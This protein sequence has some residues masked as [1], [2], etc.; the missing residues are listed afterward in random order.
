MRLEW[1][2]LLKP[3][4]IWMNEMLKIIEKYVTP[5]ESSNGIVFLSICMCMCLYI[6]YSVPPSYKVHYLKLGGN[7][8]TKLG[9]KVHL[10]VA[11]TSLMSYAPGVAG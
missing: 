2:I 7:T 3:H 8:V 6:N 4:S 1:G 5:G 10:R 9:L 11:H